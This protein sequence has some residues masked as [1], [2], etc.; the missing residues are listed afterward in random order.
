M[1][2]LN[3]VFIK[4]A[5]KI[6]QCPETGL[7]EAAFIGRSNVGKSSLINSIVL[8]KN[9]AHISS[10]PGKTRELNFYLVEDKWVL[11]DLPGFGYASTG[12]EM[13]E[14]FTKMNNEYLDKRLPIKLVCLLV[15]SRHDP[16]KHDIAL[17]EK[18]EELKRNYIIILTKCDKISK[19]S[20]LERKEQ[21]ENLVSQ[22]E[23]CS[24]VLAYSSV[25]MSGRSELIGILKK[26]LALK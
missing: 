8:R 18:M 16:M 21:V 9:L 2:P 17:I 15:D 4:G 23:F 7:P 3:A 25:D 1:K 26:K 13:R 12:K 5:V 10:A 11:A 14:M 6:E 24:E 22:C 19:K 20:V